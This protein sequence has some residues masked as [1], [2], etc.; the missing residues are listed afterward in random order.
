MARRYNVWA[1]NPDGDA[2]DPKRCLVEAYQRGISLFHQC[3]NARGED[4]L[5]GTHRAQKAAGANL[6]VPLD[7]PLWA[8]RRRP[9]TTVAPTIERVSGAGGH[10]ETIERHPAYAMIGA[11]R[12]SGRTHLYGSDFEH[13]H[14]MTIS[15][16]R[17]EM[18][19]SL[20]NDWPGAGEEYIEVA[21]SE[22]Q[23][24]TFV[25]S[26]NAGQGV[27]CTLTRRNGERI[28][29][30]TPPKSRTAQFRAELTSGLT[31]AT[32]ALADLREKIASGSTSK[33]ALLDLLGK[34]E[35]ELDPHNLAF[36]AD[37]FEEHMEDTV[38]RV[39]VEVNA[40]IT[41]QVARAGVAALLTD[42]PLRLT[43]DT[44]D[45]EVVEGE[46]VAPPPPE[47]GAA[48]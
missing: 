17:G 29:G 21:L 23:W 35:R 3:A 9:K 26:P 8:P 22:S 11:H 41:G 6:H 20:S 34:A 27:P 19:R 13:E 2:E 25:S 10:E 12:V 7:N 36:V 44:G 48:T 47:G 4:G 42:A 14:Y 15:I 39:K 16:S 43:T 37:Q 33:K 5:C 31:D 46:V 38:E 30:V 32:K 40:Y 28:L 1:G 24:A 18:R 45:D